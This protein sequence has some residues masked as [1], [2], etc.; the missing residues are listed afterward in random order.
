[1]PLDCNWRSTEL[2]VV[3]ERWRVV[4]LA[5]PRWQ[6]LYGRAA[7]IARSGHSSSP[8]ICSLVSPYIGIGW[9]IYELGHRPFLT[10]LPVI[11][12]LYLD[13]R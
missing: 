6:T 2:V 9:K 4:S 3:Q 5:I 1:M 10:K 13:K 8:N 7:P 12:L 11:S